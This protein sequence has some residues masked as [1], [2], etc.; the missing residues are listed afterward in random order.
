[1][2]KQLFFLL[3]LTPYLALGQE[4]LSECSHSRDKSLH[5]TYVGECKNGIAHGK[6]KQTT[7]MGPYEGNF[8]NG[9]RHGY[10]REVIDFNAGYQ[11]IFEGE[12]RD[13]NIWKGTRIH[14][15]KDQICTIT[16]GRMSC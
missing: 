15:G 13:D 16:R 12:F 1:M 14:T 3:M 10:G 6:G 5:A 11:L 2:Y 7:W 9:K 4:S 8:L